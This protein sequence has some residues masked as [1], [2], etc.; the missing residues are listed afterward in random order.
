MRTITLWCFSAW[1]IF[2]RL[3]QNHLRETASFVVVQQTH[4]CVILFC[5]RNQYE[6][7]LVLLVSYVWIN[8]IDMFWGP[9][10]W[11]FRHFR[12]FRRR[13]EIV[14]SYCIESNASR[15]NGGCSV[16][17]SISFVYPV[18]IKI[19]SF[20]SHRLAWMLQQLVQKLPLVHR[21]L[22]YDA[23]DVH[24]DWFQR[25]MSLECDSL[26]Q[27]KITWVVY[28]DMYSKANI[29]IQDIILAL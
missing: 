27:Y 18:S 26:W 29:N 6:F 2:L 28:W 23:C 3:V 14:F 5:L 19:L 15:G 1:L 17:V 24:I 22:H 10:K 11:P 4:L 9:P 8:V 12:C 21:G 13:H 7:G 16:N 20:C 25:Y